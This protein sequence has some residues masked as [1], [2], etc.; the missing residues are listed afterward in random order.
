M[1]SSLIYELAYGLL[2]LALGSNILLHGLV[3]W[4]AGRRQFSQGLVNDFAR[5]LLPSTWVS[6]FGLALPIVEI[7][8]GSLLVAG[9]FTAPALLV[10][11]LLMNLL[12][13]GKCLQADWPTASLQMIYVGFYAVLLWLLPANRY[14]LDTLFSLAIFNQ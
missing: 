14:A 4:Q 8:I 11:A 2:R 6:T 1:N 12:L 9:L 10:G 7:L 3:R 13:V 5:T